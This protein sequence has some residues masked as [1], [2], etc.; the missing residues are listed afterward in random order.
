MLAQIVEIARRATSARA[1]GLEKS[2]EETAIGD[3]AAGWSL[4]EEAIAPDVCLFQGGANVSSTAMRQQACSAQLSSSACHDR[5]FVA[6]SDGR[7][8]GPVAFATERE[9]LQ[10]TNSCLAWPLPA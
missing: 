10:T 5:S 6:W 9:A 4:A 8:V 1:P 3:A 2:G 7:R